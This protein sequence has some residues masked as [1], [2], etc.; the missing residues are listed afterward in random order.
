MLRKVISI[1]TLGSIYK[2]KNKFEKIYYKHIID[3]HILKIK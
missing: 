1:S 2:C 3:I